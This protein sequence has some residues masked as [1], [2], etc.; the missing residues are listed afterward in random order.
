MK[1]ARQF[2]A[3]MSSS[4]PMKSLRWSNSQ[5][6]EEFTSSGYMR[7]LF[8]Y[9]F[10]W[11]YW[12]FRY[13]QQCPLIY[14]CNSCRWINSKGR[15]RDKKWVLIFIARNSYSLFPHLFSD[16]AV[17]LRKA[18]PQLIL[19][20][21]VDLSNVAR[22]ARPDIYVSYF[23]LT[24]IPYTNCFQFRSRMYSL[25]QMVRLEL[26][27]RLRKYSPG[28]WASERLSAEQKNCKSSYQTYYLF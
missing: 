10:N 24:S 18:H 7:V 25:Q 9:L 1:S 19:R 13:R 11:Y 5:A 14:F 12:L 23:P 8:S 15:C 20:G 28:K 26:E 6:K 21:L 27:L 22:A 2:W 17:R 4:G 16:D 3:L